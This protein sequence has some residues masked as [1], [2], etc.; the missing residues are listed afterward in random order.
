MPQ[1]QSQ[2]RVIN[3]ILST[4]VQGYRQQGLIGDVLFPAVPVEVS[5]GQIIEF[6]K[7]AFMQYSTARAPGGATKRIEFGYLGK[8][9]AL[10]NH[11]LEAK[12]PREFLRD[13]KAVPS[14]DLAT[15]AVSTVMKVIKLS[16][17]IDQAALALDASKYGTNNKIALTGAS[18]WSDTT[19]D[20]GAQIESYREAVRQS[21]GVYPNVLALSAQA[22]ATLKQHSK[23]VER[24][25]FANVGVLTPDLLAAWWDLDK[26]VVGAAVKADDSGTLTDVW[27]NN[28]VLS[29]VPTAS[30]GLEEPSYGYT[31]TM[32]GHP[33]VEEPYYDNNAKS[34]IYG[35]GYERAPVLSGI[36]SGFLIQNPK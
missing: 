30:L 19:S 3:P 10:F 17:E 12:V 33:L 23:I 11:A 9:F 34:W 28:A 15:R 31:Y 14:I 32:T 18:K 8:P 35:V 4:V 13:A 2:V 7:E 1:S 27:G 21:C 36:S 26:V 16:L 24:L 29:Y 25:K 22:Y 6:G 5:G 20:P